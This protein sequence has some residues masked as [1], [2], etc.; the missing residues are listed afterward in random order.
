MSQ[1]TFDVAENIQIQVHECS[2]RV[3][4]VG[5][6]DARRVLADA[7]GRL[8]GNVLYFENSERLSLRMPRQ[9][10]LTIS[11]CEADLSISDVSGSVA[12]TDIEGDVVLRNLGEVIIRDLEGDLS[13]RQVKSLRGEGA[14]EGDVALRAIAEPLVA[15]H[16]EGDMSVG[17]IGG[18]TVESLGGDLAAR[19]VRSTVALGRVSGDVNV[20]GVQGDLSAQH[21]DGDFIASGVQ[22]AVDAQDI[23]GDAV[24]SVDETHGL[25]LRAEG[26]V[27]INL[28]SDG[29]ADV[30]LDALHGEVTHHGNIRI[31]DRDENHLR[32]TLG[33]GG[34]RVQVESL[35]GDVIAR[36][37]AAV[38][39]ADYESDLRAPFVEMGKEYKDLGRQISEEVKQS[40]NASLG[41]WGIH[42]G[43]RH[44]H[45]H[46][47]RQEETVEVEPEEPARGPAA[48]S[49]ERQAILDAIAR[50]E[51]SVDEAIRRINGEA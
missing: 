33:K 18:M 44:H 15:D 27:V 20:R 14:W 1:Q 46:A 34:S 21:V 49:P 16:I 50:G 5:W 37:G 43:R 3:T 28:P 23:E 41:K 45:I 2:E 10:S 35:R 30:E 42:H 8:E 39:H 40:V 47:S 51:L 29:D 22:G 31:L 17:D 6:E 25:D 32:G 19:G 38:P 4:V 26:D 12:L 13:A 9:A 48:G 7:P 36:T 11:D 24:V